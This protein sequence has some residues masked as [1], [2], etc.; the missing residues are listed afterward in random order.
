[1]HKM[2]LYNTLTKKI[3]DV[4][5]I[6]QP[7]VTFYSCGPTVYDN[8][9]IGHLRTFVNNDLLKK[10]LVYG[11]MNV[12]HVM[13]I[14]DVGHLSGDS[15]MGEDK[16]EKGARKYKKTVWEVAEM[17]TKQF[18]HSVNMVNILLPTT[19]CK[20][21]E[22][23][24]DMISLIVRLE[25]KGYTYQTDE[26]VYFSV[27]KFAHYGR[28]SQQK[29]TEKLQKVRSEVYVDPQKKHPADFALWFK[30]IGRFATH[31]MHWQS[32]WGDGFPGWHIEC[33]AMSMKYLGEQIDIHAG[34]I[35][36]IPVHHENEIAQS[37][38]ATDKP[39]VT[40]WFHNNFLLIEGEKMSKSQGNI[41]TI[42]DIV[43]KKIDP[44]ALRYLFLQTHYRQV[45]NFTW[46]ALSAAQ[47]AYN[48]LK[49]T[50]TQLKKQKE[51]ASLSEEKLSQTESF[52]NQFNAAIF[53]DLQI[54]QALAVL[55]ATL[56]SNIPSMDKYDLIMS[57]DEVLGLKLHESHSDDPIPTAVEDLLHKRDVAKKEKKYKLADEIRMQIEA[58]GF[59]V[60]DTSSGSTVSKKK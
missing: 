41:F 18:L 24:D 19:V 44:L 28:L 4:T 57:F 46:E 20:A 42:D 54:P 23:I 3:E 35:D 14:T 59:V 50:V 9:H 6:H 52:R 17:Y 13:N 58:E 22:H 48:K 47:I 38:A 27:E 60:Q 53:T 31:A 25:K 36:H 16:M 51:R 32:P 11:G 8:T 2:K 21:T 55:W 1:M 34:G 33:S 29:L 10:T 49:Y 40:T 5:P 15:D 12:K 43:E 39:F 37:E 56:K 30:R 26:A 7:D 45:Q